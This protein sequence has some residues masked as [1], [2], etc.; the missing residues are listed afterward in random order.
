MSEKVD[1]AIRDARLLMRIQHSGIL[2]TLSVSVAGYPFGSVTPFM[3]LG[4]GNLVI[5][6][7][8]IAQHARNMK[9]DPKVSIVSMTAV[10]MIHKRQR[11]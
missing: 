10:P 4:N 7:S 9:A 1:L 8:D 3:M 5:Y 11:V 2:S 6:A